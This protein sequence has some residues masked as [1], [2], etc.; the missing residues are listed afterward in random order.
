MVDLTHGNTQLS[1][2]EI[3][4]ACFNVHSR[5]ERVTNQRVKNE[6][7]GKGSATRVARLV[8]WFNQ[9]GVHQVNRSQHIERVLVQSDKPQAVP[10]SG[11][12]TQIV[13]GLE[14][15]LTDREHQLE[16]E[17]AERQQALELEYQQRFTELNKIGERI[18]AERGVMQDEIDHL[19]AMDVGKNQTIESYVNQLSALEQKYIQTDARLHSMIEKHSHKEAE[20]IQF[21]NE[22]AAEKQRQNQLISTVT[23]AL[24][25]KY[26]DKVLLLEST[27]KQLEQRLEDADDTYEKDT[28]LWMN[29]YDATR[30]ERDDYQI[31]YT[32]LKQKLFKFED[33]LRL[34]R[35]SLTEKT[36]ENNFLKDENAELKS[37]LDLLRSKDKNVKFL[38]KTNKQL[39]RKLFLSS[40][41]K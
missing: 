6:L 5:G 22:L 19:R 30:I 14:S 31:K 3:K 33:E 9:E 13:A 17:F 18:K 20:I 36:L 39:L 40:K 28:A 7:D 27:I 37:T 41:I 11:A 21:E 32:E 10:S 12:I 24:E 34:N 26:V 8:K 29:K 25:E 1:D 2:D 23:T 4:V 38:I 16:T 35:A 15:A